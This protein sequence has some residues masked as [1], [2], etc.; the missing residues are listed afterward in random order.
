VPPDG[1]RVG[2]EDEL[3]RIEAV[4]ALRGEG[5][6]DP[7]AVQLARVDVRQ[8]AVPDHVGLLG[9]RDRH[10]L[11]LGIE[12]V[13]QAELDAG[14]V[15]REDGEVDADAVPRGAERI[16]APGQ[17]RRLLLEGTRRRMPPV[18][19]ARMV[20]NAGVD[21]LLGLVPLVGDAADVAWKANLRN[22]AL[23]E[24]HARGTTAPSTSDY[25]FVS[26]CIGAVVLIALVPVLLIAWLITQVPRLL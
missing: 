19:L 11:G 16:G 13:E 23:L 7:V 12:R 1:L 10:R 8:V 15:L 9:Q 2:V 6:V 25:V 26:I 4:A 20:L 14:R 5:A 22:L 17:T 3:V 24:R 21:M 18:V